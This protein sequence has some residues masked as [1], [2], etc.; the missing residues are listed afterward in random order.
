MR[1]FKSL[2][3]SPEG[4]AISLG[5]NGVRIGSA[6]PTNNPPGFEE[7]GVRGKSRVYSTI[8]RKEVI[9]A[10]IKLAGEFLR[11]QSSGL[12]KIQ[13]TLMLWSKSRGRAEDIHTES[14]IFMQPIESTLLRKYQNVPLFGDGTEDPLKLHY[15]ESGRR[16][17]LELHILP[18]LG[19]ASFSAL[20][21][22]S[23]QKQGIPL[24]LLNS[25]G[26]EVM[27]QRL[28]VDSRIGK[29]N[30]LFDHQSG[31]RK[32]IASHRTD[33][34]QPSIFFK[35]IKKALSGSFGERFRHKLDIAP[36]AHATAIKEQ[37]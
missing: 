28:Q 23:C 5:I 26:G 31:T 24:S 20:R 29:L 11:E 30:Q 22:A 36:K 18:L 13:Q 15:L 17:Y 19:Q 35:F 7:L 37:Y 32:E 27:T 9:H 2:Q 3:P 33:A 1:T 8:R 10:N 6:E 16:E 21:I 4:T 14:I 12:S 34:T 25:C